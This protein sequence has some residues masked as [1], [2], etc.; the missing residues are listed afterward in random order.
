MYE[1][2]STEKYSVEKIAKVLKFSTRNITHRRELG[3]I[4]R[5][6]SDKTGKWQVINQ[7]YE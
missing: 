7:K 1:L 4:M 3:L 5:I 6:G 2:I